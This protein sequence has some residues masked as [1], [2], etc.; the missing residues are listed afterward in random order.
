MAAESPLFLERYL[1]APVESMLATHEPTLMRSQVVEVGHLASGKAGRG[2]FLMS[3][4]GAHLA[5]QSYRWVVGTATSEVR[6][7]FDR[8]GVEPIV[9]GMA[10]PKLLG[11]EGRALGQLLRPSAG[12]PRRAHAT[13]DESTGAPVATG[14]RLKALHSWGGRLPDGAHLHDGHRSWSSAQVA[15]EVEL[16]ATFLREQRV[17]VLATLADNSPAWAVIDMAAAQAGVVHVPLPMFFTDEQVTYVLRAAGVDT[18]S[19][20]SKGRRPLARRTV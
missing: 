4:L 7:M 17:R 13:F 6:Q 12:G 15:A 11:D 5:A 16:L 10:N 19:L 18:V 8:V 3:L 9:L 20:P 1:D 14:G 2:I